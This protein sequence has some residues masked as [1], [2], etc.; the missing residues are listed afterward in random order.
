[1]IIANLTGGLGNQMFQYAFGRAIAIKN[2]TNLKLHFVNALF[3]TQRPYELNVFNISADLATKQDLNKYGI[4]ENKA[5]NRI[6]YLLDERLGIQ[7]NNH[8]ITQKYPYLWDQKYLSIKNDTYLQGFWFGVKYFKE[9][10]DIIR[11]EFTPKTELDDKNQKL[12]EQMQKKN[13]VSVHVR[14][15]D[16]VSSNRNDKFIGL[17]YYIKVYDSLKKRVQNPTFFIFSDDIEWCRHNLSKLAQNS[18]YVDHNKGFNSYKDLLLMAHCKHNVVANSSFSWW[19]S[20]LN[21]NSNKI[22]IS[23][24][25]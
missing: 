16:L 20:W 1:M 21:I 9:I 18:I 15:G 12:I 4:V 2:N 22:V 8:I 23:P 11:N 24:F 14:R 25:S 17:D 10:E 19:G 6:L 3:N 5:L 7:F 13:S